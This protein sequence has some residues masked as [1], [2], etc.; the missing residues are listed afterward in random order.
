MPSVQREKWVP[1]EGFRT[2]DSAWIAFLSEGEEGG[3]GVPKVAGRKNTELGRARQ[4]MM[5]DEQ[6]CRLLI[7]SSLM[8]CFG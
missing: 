5:T 7:I 8:Q 2:Q 3:G 1:T 4:G 6:P